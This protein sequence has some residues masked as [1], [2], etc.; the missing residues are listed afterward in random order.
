MRKL[1]YLL[2]TKVNVGSKESPVLEERL[3]RVEME[4]SEKNLAIAQAEAHLGV[5]EIVEK[6][7]AE[8][9]IQ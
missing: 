6:E 8:Q 2:C 4:Y 5:Y 3:A 9:K 1:Q 7:E